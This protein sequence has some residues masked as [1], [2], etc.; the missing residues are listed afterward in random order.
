MLLP[1]AAAFALATVLLWLHNAQLNRQLAEL[2]NTIEQQQKELA[3]T[4]HQADLIAAR[5]TLVVPLWSQKG[6]TAGH[7]RRARARAL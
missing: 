7:A 2:R 6:A 1:A 3:E 5:E 4:R